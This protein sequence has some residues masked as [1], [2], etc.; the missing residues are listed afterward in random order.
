MPRPMRD[1][2]QPHSYTTQSP[3]PACRDGRKFARDNIER[4]KSAVHLQRPVK[5]GDSFSILVLLE[6][7]EPV[8]ESS[9]DIVNPGRVPTF[10]A[11]LG[12]C[13]V[14]RLDIRQAQRPI[15]R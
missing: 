4:R 5:G 1:P 15:Q 12:L 7:R 14:A 11:R 8:Q 10:P 6:E 3:G 2:F 13:D 9:V